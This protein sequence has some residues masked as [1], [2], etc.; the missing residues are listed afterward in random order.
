[1]PITLLLD[2]DDTLLINPFDSFMPLYLKILS[3]KL[4][5]FVAPE[6]MIPQL[7]A[8]TDRMINNDSCRMTLE[9]T[10]DEYFYPSLGL[11]KSELEPH[12]IDF[13]LSDFN[14][15]QENTLPRQ[16]SID[17]VNYARSLNSTVVVA[18]NPLFPQEAMHARLHWAG[19]SED[20]F[21]FQFV[22]SFEAMHFSKPNP[23]YYAE[24]LG[25]FG[26]PR[27]SIYMIGNSLKEDILPPAVFGIPGFWVDG[28]DEK[29]PESIRELSTTG[30][31]EEVI[32]WL[33]KLDKNPREVS[34]QDSS[35]I[36]AVLKSTPAV[37][38]HLTGPL[39]ETGWKKKSSSEELSILELIS[40]LLDV[41][42]EINF[43]R[44]KD[45]LSNENPNILGVDSDVWVEQR[46]YQETRT[47]QVIRDFTEQRLKCINLLNELTPDQWNRPA[48]HS[49]FGPTTLLE[50]MR[51]IAV[52]DIDHIRQVYRLVTI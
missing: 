52:H 51:F 30:K 40:H 8:A 48:R 27:T 49:F 1:M 44:I 34:L 15:L 46:K 29:I 12:L 28:E 7:L 41:E 39:S 11:Q 31:M 33:K 36:L 6:K 32:P 25:R 3:K 2:L 42:T 4:A 38:Q 20:D 22:T 9:Q 13:Y 18:T 16:E 50:L 5:P 21:P 37:L 35:A 14:E 23:A 45:V 26:W 24:I 43:S 17:L 19:F 10:F 47:S